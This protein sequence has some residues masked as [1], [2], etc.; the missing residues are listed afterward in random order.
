M[1]SVAT[2]GT[3][4]LVGNSYLPNGEPY[5]WLRKVDSQGNILWNN[6][7]FTGGIQVAAVVATSDDGAALA[8]NSKNDFWL[9]K[10]DS[11]GNEEWKQTYVYGAITDQHFVY[12]MAETKDGGFILAGAGN[13]Q[14]SGGM[15]PWLVKIDSQ[16][17]D[18]WNLAY[19][20]YSPESYVAVV[21]TTDEGYLVIKA[22]NPML[23]RT[24]PG[25]SELWNIPLSFTGGL[26]SSYLPSDL[27]HTA[28]GGYALV[29]S[30]GAGSFLVKIS[31]EA[32]LQ[33][34]EVTILSPKS[35]TYETG[36]IPLTFKVNKQVSWLGYS[37]DGQDQVTIEGNT[38]LTGLV[39]GTHN[40]T[41]YARDQNGLVDNSDALQ[42]T[43]AAPFPTD[44]GPRRDRRCHNG[45]RKF[46]T[47]RE[48]KKPRR[49]EETRH[50]KSCR[51]TN[52]CQNRE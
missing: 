7:Q 13:W 33:P 24:D 27:I 38:T 25:G 6:T 26:T 34:L 12:S 4:I 1:Q 18:K 47:I 40:I 45:K 3:F 35:K 32:D 51:K 23:I 2:D 21:Q 41:V 20:Q 42:F 37:L 5:A 36:D 11:N 14:S 30:S 15:V 50:K 49:L 29:D 19:G 52:S 16:G 31:L 9:C 39:V 46:S 44:T 28:D 8:G 10:L 43:I 17:H 22:G 48:E